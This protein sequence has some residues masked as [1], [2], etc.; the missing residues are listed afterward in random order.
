MKEKL[1]CAGIV[2]LDGIKGLLS[3]GRASR[4]EN[5]HSRPALFFPP[6]DWRK[7]V[8]NDFAHWLKDLDKATSAPQAFDLSHDLFQ[9]MTELS[10]FRQEVKRQ[11]REQSKQNE[12]L[13]RMEELYR[14]ALD[15]VN[16]RGEDLA[17]LRQDV[18]LATERSVFLLFADLRDVLQ[19][20]LE[21]SRRAPVQKSFFRRSLPAR[22]GVEEGYQIAVDRFDRAMAK[23]NIGKVP[24]IG[25]PFDSRLMVAIA[26]RHQSGIQRGIVLEE[27]MSGYI[28]GEEILRTAQVV[29]ASE[30]TE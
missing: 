1:V 27:S 10:S 9:V 23:L 26:T 3:F 28:R 18:Q 19:R 17:A 29:V 4:H 15:R 5:R 22:E 12:E 25:R 2:L 7:E 13:V 21:E 16:T 14:E 20:G 8:L 24:T 30:S 6:G 11:S